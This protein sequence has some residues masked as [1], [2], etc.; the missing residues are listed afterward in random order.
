MADRPG[1]RRLPFPLSDRRSAQ[2][3]NQKHPGESRG[4]LELINFKLNHP[5]QITYESDMRHF[6][7]ADEMPPKKMHINSANIQYSEKIPDN[8][9][10]VLKT[11][12]L[13]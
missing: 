12:M 9:Y 4:R 3:N 1:R 10:Y 5:E 6:I 8:H 2:I 11:V 7:P 13:V